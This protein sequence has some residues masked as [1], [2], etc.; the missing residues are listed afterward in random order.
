MQGP[1]GGWLYE[2]DLGGQEPLGHNA[3]EAMKQ[4][5]LYARF[6]A[7]RESMSLDELLSDER[8]RPLVMAVK[9]ER[10]KSPYVWFN[11]PDELRA[12]IESVK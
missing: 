6:N 2:D 9:R 1:R 12:A 8:L 4:I 5:I 3:V 10:D 11:I 7:P